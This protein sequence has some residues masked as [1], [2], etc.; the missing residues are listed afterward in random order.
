[1]KMLEHTKLTLETFVTIGAV[2]SDSLSVKIWSQAALRLVYCNEPHLMGTI[3]SVISITAHKSWESSQKLRVIHQHV[4]DPLYPILRH[5]TS[6]VKCDR[7]L[8]SA[9]QLLCAGGIAPASF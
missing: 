9:V 3:K 6:Q 4:K 2:S 8:K 7:S 5:H 1:M